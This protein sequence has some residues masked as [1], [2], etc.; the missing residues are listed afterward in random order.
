MNI[1]E[2]LQKMFYD[3]RLGASKKADFIKIVRSRYPEIKV[4]D[5]NEWLSN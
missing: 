2:I 4:K 5:I 1:T 3:E